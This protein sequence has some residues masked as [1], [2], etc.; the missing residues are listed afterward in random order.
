VRGGTSSISF[1]CRK[2]VAAV[3]SYDALRMRD[4]VIAAALSDQVGVWLA[5]MPTSTNPQGLAEVREAIRQRLFGLG[6]AEIR[7]VAPGIIIATR[8]GLGPIRLGFTGHY[9]IESAGEGWTCEPFKA[10]RRAGRIFGRGIADNLGPLWLKL[11]A[12][13]AHPGP[14][15]SLLVIIQGEEEIGSP[16]A[17]RVLPSTDLPAVDLWLEE[18]G[19]FELD[20][21]QRILARNLDDRTAPL[22]LAIEQ[23]AAA[24]GRITRRHDRFLN[25]AFGTNRCPFLTHL[26]RNNP[27]LAFGPND[28]ASAIHAPDESLPEAHLD[29]SVRQFSALLSAAAGVTQ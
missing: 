26:V 22:V 8:A 14:T 5:A 23:V 29:L 27:Y 9:D 17:H 6:F 4:E 12:L 25:K 10:T 16:E 18:T 2:N 1:S 24:N 11:A 21:S 19:Y 3:E 13:E 7:S 20:G 28:P 15:P